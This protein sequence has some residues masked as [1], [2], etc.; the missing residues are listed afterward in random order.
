MYAH[1][2]YNGYFWDL[3]ASVTKLKLSFAVG[4]AP[5]GPPPIKLKP[6][7]PAEGNNIITK[8]KLKV[9]GEEKAI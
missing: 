4:L 2:T 6:L 1:Y 9:G 7:L 3:I 5:A 8:K